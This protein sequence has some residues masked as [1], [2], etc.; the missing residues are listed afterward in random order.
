MLLYYDILAKLR[1]VNQG[2]AHNL[3]GWKTRTRQEVRRSEKRRCEGKA[4]ENYSY[5]WRN[6]KITEEI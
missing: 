4:I 1:Q 2:G 3:T 6:F 5:N